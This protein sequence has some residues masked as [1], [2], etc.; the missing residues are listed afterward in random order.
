VIGDQQPEYDEAF[1]IKLHDA[2]NARLADRWGVVTI[3]DNEPR[4]SINDVTATEGNAGTTLL[5]FTAS[6]L[7]AHDHAV[8]VNFATQDLSASAGED[9]LATSG[10]LTF[11]PCETSKLITIEVRGDNLPE[12][13]EL[14]VVNLGGATNALVTK[15][16]GVGTILDDDGWISPPPDPEPVYPFDPYG[17][18]GGG[19]Y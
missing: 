3:I 7:A 8:S 19:G 5:T 10:T 9:Y 4:I 12:P 15:S 14:F 18:Y 11:A 13:S 1:F 17:P 6:L 2:K 16:Y